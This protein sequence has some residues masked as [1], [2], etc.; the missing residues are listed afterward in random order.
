MRLGLMPGMGALGGR[1]AWPLRTGF[2]SAAGEAA[3]PGS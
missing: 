3:E 1:E 2:N